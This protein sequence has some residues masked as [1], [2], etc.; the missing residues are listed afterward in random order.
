MYCGKGL[1]LMAG[2][3]LAFL[4]T[5]KKAGAR[6]CKACMKDRARK[7]LTPDKA[8]EY[9]NRDLA[10]HGERRNAERRAKYPEQRERIC[11]RQ[12]EYERKKF[13][14]KPKAQP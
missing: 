2:D 14:W 12:R 10:K 3:N 1:H 11:A 6:M 4:K 7:H 5:G 8:K 9:R 13:G